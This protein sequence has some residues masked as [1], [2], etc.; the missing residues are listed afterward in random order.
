V[1]KT[2]RKALPVSDPRRLKTRARLA[3]AVLAIATERPISEVTVSELAS[4]AGV[5]RS[6]FYEHAESPGELLQSVLRSELDE[7][8]IPLVGAAREDSELA[9]TRV[10]AGVLRHVDSHESIYLR[11][12][13]E[14]SGAASLHAMLSSH[15]RGSIDLLFE[16]DT[17]A[18]PTG[19]FLDRSTV[20]AFIADGTVG[21]IEVWLTTAKPRNVELFLARFSQLVP[22]WWPIR[23]YASRPSAH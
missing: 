16:Q 11:G 5:H 6:T 1:R 17:V 18:L 20:A 15:F 22:A 19:S 7:L 14:G 2:C 3:A 9:V 10:T 12:L 23:G 4:A 21:A 8:R 13:G